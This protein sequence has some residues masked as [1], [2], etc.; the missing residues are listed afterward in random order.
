MINTSVLGP[1]NL[2][3]AKFF[4]KKKSYNNFYNIL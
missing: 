3:M 4:L 2:L 1:N